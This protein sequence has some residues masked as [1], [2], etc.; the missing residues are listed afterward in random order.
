MDETS[1]FAEGIH[2]PAHMQLL[3]LT[4]WVHISMVTAMFVYLFPD[5]LPPLQLESHRASRLGTAL[6][7]ANIKCTCP[8]AK[9]GTN[10]HT[11]T[12]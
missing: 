4:S 5:F 2:G 6:F 12:F 8:C 10:V 1:V 11:P 3:F 7:V 9:L